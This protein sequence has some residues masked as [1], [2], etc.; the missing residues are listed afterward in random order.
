MACAN[1]V[2]LSEGRGVHKRQRAKDENET[3]EASNDSLS[4]FIPPKNHFKN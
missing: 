1:R 2:G 3:D 4:H